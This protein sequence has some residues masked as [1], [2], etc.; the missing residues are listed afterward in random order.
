MLVIRCKIL[1]SHDQTRDSRQ[2]DKAIMDMATRSWSPSIQSLLVYL[3]NE[4]N[5]EVRAA[6]QSTAGRDMKFGG[7]PGSVL[8]TQFED[9]QRLAGTVEDPF[10]I[11]QSKEGPSR[12]GLGAEDR[13][14]AQRQDCV[15]HQSTK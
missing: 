9:G 2:M 5:G 3:L 12:E 15:W 8:D 6:H 1:N 10:D 4:A 13:C 14:A 11:G 7:L